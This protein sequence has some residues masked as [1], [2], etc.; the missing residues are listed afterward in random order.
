MM[1]LLTLM[2]NNTVESRFFEP[3]RETEIGSKNREFEKSKAL[4]LR[5]I[6]L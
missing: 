3:P 4:D 6:V 2:D 5:G 1:S